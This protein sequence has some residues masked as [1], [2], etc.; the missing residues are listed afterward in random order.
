MHQ[1]PPNLAENTGSA[2]AQPY[3]A[4]AISRVVL[5]FYLLSLPACVQDAGHFGPGFFPL[6]AALVL[7]P[8]FF[9]LCLLDAVS[10]CAEAIAARTFRQHWKVCLLSV[11]LTAGYA[12][13]IALVVYE[14]SH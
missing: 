5:A 14:R 8:V 1:E 3:S 2:P 11:L 12:A 4:R 10:T 6:L 7:V 13:V 9:L